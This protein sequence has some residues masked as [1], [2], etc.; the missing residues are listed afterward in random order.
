MS[1]RNRAS[2]A[3]LLCGVL[4][5]VCAAPVAAQSLHKDTVRGFQFKPPKEFKSVAL[6]PNEKRVIAKYQNES[7]DNSGDGGGMLG[8]YYQ[9]FEV[10]FFPD[11]KLLGSLTSVGED[12]DEPEDAGG[13][14]SKG[15]MVDEDE[16]ADA[17]PVD[18]IVHWI[19]QIVGDDSPEKEKVVKLAG[20]EGK[21]IHLTSAANPLRYYFLVLQQKEGVFVFEG[22]ALSQRFDKAVG[23]FSKAAKSFKRIEK[24]DVSAHE[25][26]LSQMSEQDRFLQQQIDKLPPGWSSMHTR[27]YLFLYNADK[28]FVKELADRI[29][30][31][32]DAYEELYQPDKPITAVSIVRVCNSMEEYFGYGGPQGSGGYWSYRARELE[33]FDFRPR[34][35][36]LAVLNHEAFHQFIFYFYGQ[37]SPHSWYNEGHGDYFA[38][39]KMTKSNRIS[40]FGDAPGGIGRLQT[41]KEG[42]RL[43][44]EGKKGRDGAAAPL[45][46]VMHFHQSDYY[47]NKG[48]DIGVCYAEGWSIV[49]MLRQGRSLKPKWERILPDY[50]AN[51]LAARDEVAT[52]LMNKELADAEKKEAGSSADLSKDLSE[53]Y[54]KIDDDKVQDLTYDKTFK[55]WSKEDW[56][57][58]Q[59][60][61]LGYVEKL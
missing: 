56:A 16:D 17:T 10:S 40:G 50:L 58:F 61:W 25:A 7:A 32:R 1:C 60:F 21:E 49:H 3:S 48:F 55:D 47:G 42:A 45:K 34:E 15:G 6:Q 8:G 59:D 41:I 2:I 9:N 37:L 51:L 38:G 29:E 13:A 44:S 31:M 35:L 30:G 28:G 52:E 43:L 20:G 14:G 54:E 57:D 19:E 5:L 12:P 24:D 27:R 33:F 4:S 39:A 53:Y 22:S 11:G 18:R 36:T 23:E 46:D 26:D